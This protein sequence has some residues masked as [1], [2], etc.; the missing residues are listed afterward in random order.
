MVMTDK[1]YKNDYIHGSLAYE[2]VPEKEREIKRKK[3]KKTSSSVQ[4]KAKLR[5]MTR[6]GFIFVFAFLMVMRFTVIMKATHDLRETKKSIN[7]ITM[8]N[9]NLRVQL[10]TCDNIKNIETVATTKLGMALPADGQIKYI[11]VKPIYAAVN[12]IKKN[13]VNIIHRFFGLIN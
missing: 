5:M 3:I 9:E 6:I 12:S 11:A 13:D 2:V 7:E 10:A 8:A 1:K 4:V